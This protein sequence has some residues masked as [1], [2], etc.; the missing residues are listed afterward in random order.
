MSSLLE[1]L[2]LGIYFSF[3][4]TDQTSTQIVIIQDHTVTVLQSNIGLEIKVFYLWI[5]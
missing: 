3:D 1:L 4:I 5:L 2:V